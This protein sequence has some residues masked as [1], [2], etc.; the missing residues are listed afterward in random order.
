MSLLKYEDYILESVIYDLI[1]ESEIVYSNKFMKILTSMRSNKIANNLLDLYK[2]D[3]NIQHNYIDL[4]DEKD[5]VSFTPDRKV[6]EI[7][8]DKDKLTTYEVIN[9]QKYLTHGAT[10]NRIFELLE[11]TKP[12]SDP[13]SPPEG[14]IGVILREVISPTSGKTFAIFKDLNSER[15][16]VINKLEGLKISDN[17]NDSKIWSSSRNNIKVGRLARAIL[18]A[19]KITFSDKDI[20]DFSNSFKATFDTMSDVLKQFDVV[21]GNDIAYWYNYTRYKTGNGSLNNSCMSEVSSRYFDIYTKNSQV[22]LVILYDDDGV[23]EDGKYKS[24]K[25]KGRAI[26]WDCEFKDGS[27]IIFMDR[28]YSVSESDIVLFKQFAEKNGWWYKVRQSYDLDYRSVTNGNETV[29]KKIICKLDKVDFDSYPYVDTLCFISL[30][31]KT[32]SNRKKNADRAL[33]STDGEYADPE[34]Y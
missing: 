34:D 4:T 13:W 24:R 10:N 12:E 7:I 16:T 25:I 3:V 1:L 21:K 17:I 2:K 33:R 29:E 28:I 15:K 5:T 32:A 22:S 8:T 30:D 9:S 20:E 18:T 6:K 27:K 14:T 19:S 23:I 11:Y 26:L 31:D